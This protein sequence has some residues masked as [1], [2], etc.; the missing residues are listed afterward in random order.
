MKRIVLTAGL[1]LL[2]G[3]ASFAT[4]FVTQ[5]KTNTALGDYKITRDNQTM[6]INGK[7]HVP[8]VIT[9]ENSDLEVRVAIDMDRN[10]K[11]Y[12]VIT[13]NLCVQYVSN[14]KYFGV[15]K[16][17]KELEIYGLN[18]NDA[19]LN[20][21]EYFHQKLITTDQNWKDNNTDLVA[22]YFPLLM[23]N[24]EAVLAAK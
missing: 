20:R 11:K 4:K 22:A 24:V 17:G 1:I 14:K 18:T 16:L 13:N 6:I 21:V 7:Q 5:G 3:V 19:A 2:F 8:Y 12:Y 10:G 15:E 23:N 9:Y